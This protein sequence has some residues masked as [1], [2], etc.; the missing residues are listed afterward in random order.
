VIGLAKQQ[1][2]LSSYLTGKT[3]ADAA[4]ILG[5]AGHGKTTLAHETAIAHGYQPLTVYGSDMRSLTMI[6]DLTQ[7]TKSFSISGAKI[8]IIEEIEKVKLPHLGTLVSSP[9]K[10][11]FICQDESKLNWKVK[12]MSTTIRIPKISEEN[13]RE[14]LGKLSDGARIEKFKSWWDCINFMEGGT[15]YEENDSE[16]TDAL[17]EHYSRVGNP[18]IASRL[19]YTRGLSPFRERNYRDVISYLTYATRES[20][21][22]IRQEKKLLAHKKPIKILGFYD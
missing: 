21:G 11:I 9:G 6:Q 16:E 13:Y 5:S 7:Q 2:I 14:K 10:K 17:L 12:K 22:K 8:I 20:G 4:L 1:M 18:D 3:S 15:I 19:N